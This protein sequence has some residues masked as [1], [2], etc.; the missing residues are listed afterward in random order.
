[1]ITKE[2]FE[3]WCIAY[4]EEYKEYAKHNQDKILKIEVPQELKFRRFYLYCDKMGV[5]N[6]ILYFIEEVE[7]RSWTDMRK[8]REGMNAYKY[9]LFSIP[10]RLASS[11]IGIQE[12]D[13]IGTWNL[14]LIPSVSPFPMLN[15]INDNPFEVKQ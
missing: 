8:Y 12:A 3:Q 1:M 5:P 6:H 4:V 11:S 14:L 10:A 7:D 15:W 9:Y 13:S 2:Q